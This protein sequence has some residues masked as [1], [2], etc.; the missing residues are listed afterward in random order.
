MK[1][2]L[3]NPINS[4]IFFALLLLATCSPCYPWE[5]GCPRCTLSDVFGGDYWGTLQT[6]DDEVFLSRRGFFSLRKLH[7]WDFE[8]NHFRDPRDERTTKPLVKNSYLWVYEAEGSQPS[9]SAPQSK[10]GSKTFFIYIQGVQNLNACSRGSG[11][12]IELYLHFS[13]RK[14]GERVIGQW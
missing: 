1:V 7:G 9:S 12:W 10:P 5:N 2:S 3:T 14:R 11:P 8:H 4:G 6:Q 13:V